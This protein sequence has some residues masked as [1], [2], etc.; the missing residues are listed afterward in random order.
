MKFAEALGDLGVMLLMS[1][2][3]IFSSCFKWLRFGLEG[4]RF[5]GHRTSF[6]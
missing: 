4:E 5:Y 3:Q 6:H 2:Q 1:L